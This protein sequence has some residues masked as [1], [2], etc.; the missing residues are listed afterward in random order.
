MDE[1]TPTALPAEQDEQAQPDE[2][3]TKEDTTPLNKE[4]LRTFKAKIA[5]SKKN[6]HDFT[7]TWKGNIER[8]LGTAIKQY[9]AGVDVEDDLQSEINPDW[10]LTK[11]KV[12]NLFSQVPTIQGT[13][14]VTTYAPAVPPF[15]KALN[16]E[17]GEKRA[18]VGTAMEESLA[19]VVNASGI[20]GVEV[21]Y[22]ARFEQ[23]EMPMASSL[24]MPGGQPGAP[25]VP[26]P[27]E[28]ISSEVLSAIIAKSKEV[29][30]PI[31]TQMVDRP[32]DYKFYTTRISPGDLL[33][34]SDF[35]GSNF[36]DGEWIGR[37]GTKTWAEA[38]REWKLKDE[39]KDDIC[40]TGKP[41]SQDDL[42]T[43]STDTKSDGDYVKYDLL[44]YKRYF[45]DEDER[46]FS[47][48]WKLVIV[49]GVDDPV[50]HEAWKGQKYDEDRRKFV[51]ATKF[52][53]RVGTI[54]YVSDNPVPPSDTQAARPLVDD[55]R[56][57]RSQLFQSR[58]RSIP[59]R[60]FD[61]NRID[62]L[63]QDNLMRGVVQGMIPTNGD[64]SRSI[65]EI[66]R[67]NYPSEDFTFD[68][69]T[70]SDLRE[71]WQ[72]DS[73]QLGVAV[74]RKT[75]AQTGAEQESFATRIGQERTKI[76][77]LF[78]GI[79]EVV[80]GLMVLYSDF[81]NLTD[82]ER[83]TMQQAWD[84]KHILH[85]LV[86]KL[87]PDATVML[88]SQTRIQRL[89]QFLNITGQSGYVN[90]MPIIM[91]IAELSGLDP[92]TVII[93]P[94]PKVEE[95]NISYRF[96]GKDDLLN[97]MVVGILIKK[98]QA[99]TAE[100]LNQAKQLLTSA[101]APPQEAPPQPDPNTVPPTHAPPGD[102]APH[103]AHIKPQME[104]GLMP[105][106]AKR[107]RDMGAV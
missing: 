71:S 48:I 43:D 87:R 102:T 9:T 31:P 49:E 26:T 106:I 69:I 97:P 54:T 34:P 52:P 57:S 95:P 74:G 68:Q 66:S 2:S 105:K 85:D 62:P 20:C 79:A 18:Y 75:S 15:L 29:G 104:G 53:I 90:P 30:Q 5:S 96:S 88:D 1:L 13:H 103:P 65:G 44:Y 83:Q 92:N 60:W 47:A 35:T 50:V 42:S 36:D 55:I 41:D 17:L 100:E 40:T 59:I 56:R 3:P 16:Y 7:R 27:V 61:V 98:G 32:T 22:M 70:K 37:S 33:W 73:T 107:G 64:G 67:A 78:L 81:P 45:F 4:I 101:L 19:D 51:G 25:P 21:G 38:K 46:S 77:S 12:A 63:L 91:E 89:T 82:Q 86:L 93:Q 14:E 84:Q 80:A 72:L 23:V 8:R 10:S 28:Q 99:P 58:Q 94:Q 39:L 6:R 24:P 76:A 11:V